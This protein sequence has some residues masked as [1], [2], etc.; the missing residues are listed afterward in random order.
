MSASAAAGHDN[1]A[2]D[3]TMR[4]L[5][6]TNWVSVRALPSLN[7]GAALK[8]RRWR[9]SRPKHPAIEEAPARSTSPYQAR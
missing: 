1:A 7:T 9:S 2:V 6:R 3:S 5:A 8:D 4:S